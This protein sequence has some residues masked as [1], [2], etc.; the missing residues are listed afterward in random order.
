ME[1]SLRVVYLQAAAPP[2]AIHISIRTGLGEINTEIS[3]LRHSVAL[4]AFHPSDK[5]KKSERSADAW[6]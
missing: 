1:G 3:E 6:G 4:F 5:K 2:S